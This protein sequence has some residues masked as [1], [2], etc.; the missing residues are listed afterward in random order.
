ML[1]DDKN[2]MSLR[3]DTRKDWPRVEVTRG[4]K[5]DGSKHFGPY[6]SA[7][8]VRR[9]LNVLNKHFLLRTCPDYVLNN[10]SRPCLQYQI[11]RCPAPCVFEL[12]KA[13]YEE[14]VRE[15][16]MFLEGR[17]SQ[18]LDKLELRML[19]AAEDLQFE[20]AAHYRDQIDAIKTSMEAQQAVTPNA[21][22][23][24][25]IGHYREADRV[26]V[27]LLV[28]RRGKMEG[29]NAWAFKD[30][31][32]PDE[33][34]LSSFLNQ[35]YGHGASIPH[36]VILPV[37]LEDADALQDILSERRGTRVSLHCPVRGKKLELLELA[38]R[39]AKAAFVGQSDAGER[40]ADLLDKL[41]AALGL[42]NHPDRIEC[43]DISNFQ[44]D[45]IVGSMAVFEGGEP[46]SKE[47][48]TFKVKT[49]TGQ[50]D[51]ASMYEVLQR[52]L[53]RSLHDD[54]PRPDLLVI[55]GGKGQ[56]SQAIA[57]ATDLGIH[58]LD[59]VALAKSR[60]QSDG[61]SDA[62]ER[63]LER[64]FL[65]G[66][67]NPLILRQNSAELFLLQRIRDEAHR[68]AITY[69]RKLRRRKTLHSNLDEI[70][71]VGPGRKKALLDHFGS[72]DAIRDA[73]VAELTRAPGISD[74]LAREVYAFFNSELAL[75]DSPSEG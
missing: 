59:I 11:K 64:V 45:P 65:P 44:G 40:T 62:I 38:Q 63:S 41:Q 31:E 20:L 12:D 51:F 25:I 52:R 19:L 58:D 13:D 6:H 67:K 21:T 28:I 47:Y 30:Q 37:E 48:R 22:D 71:G 7:T 33:E 70:P 35:Y 10:R 66:R 50:D 54:W 5:R 16:I 29:A 61:R 4:I 60:P 9:T 1:R 32:F 24:D 55:D 3:I 72:L 36:E 8:A 43:F 14:H 34:L 57:V 53:E 23:Q 17:S 56:L 73:T 74:T 68:F 75:D 49:V 2:Y 39:N 46:A 18:L 26:A 27:H 69:H 15:A 42:T